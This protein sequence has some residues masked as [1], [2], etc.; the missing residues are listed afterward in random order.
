MKCPFISG[1]PKSS[2]GFVVV[3]VACGNPLRS[4]ALSFARSLARGRRPRENS[5]IVRPRREERARPARAG[6]IINT[7]PDQAIKTEP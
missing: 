3:R 5:Y 4:L 2:A 6:T 7:G 1:G